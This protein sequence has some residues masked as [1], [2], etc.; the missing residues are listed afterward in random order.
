M[1]NQI[2]VFDTTLRDGTQGEGINLSVQDKLLIA[3]R[4][5][6]FGIDIIE[7]GWPGSNP[8]DEEFF[9]KV[10]RSN[11]HKAEICAFG[12]TARSLNKIEEDQN[13]QAILQ[14]ET[15]VVTIFGKTWKLHSEKGLGISTEENAELIFKSVEFLKKHGKRVIYD[16]E[17]FFDGY[18]DDNE[19]SLKMIK[20]AEAAGA[21][22]IV[23]CDTNGGTLP[24]EVYDIVL[25]LK[26]HIHSP[27]GIHTH[28]DSELAVANSIAAIEAGAV[29]VQGTINGVGERCGN[30][31]LCSI[32]PNLILKLKKTTKQNINLEHLT[33]LS[34][35]VFELMNLTPNSRIAYVGKSAFAHKGGIHV[36]A[37]LKDSRMYEHIDPKV[38]G[39]SQRV[40]VSDLSG[41][42]NI[43]YKAKELGIDL[44]DKKELSKRLVNYIKDLEY[45]GFQFD[46]AEASFELLLRS[47]LNEFLPFFD[48]LDSKVN[49]FYDK[50][51]V[52]KA[53]AVLKIKV[54]GEIEHT[55]AD[56]DGPVNALDN[57]LRKALLRFY[58]D[59]ALIKLVDYKVRVLNEKEGTAAKVRVIIESSDGNETWST[60][61]VSE[62]II[63][64]SFQALRDSINYK[65][66]KFQS[67][68]AKL[69]A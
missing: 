49:V 37:V 2:E 33:S 38:V 60:V 67:S 5:D 17:H 16:A 52:S 63:E 30:A 59:I 22:V 25:K 10:K 27:I 12:S 36:S 14:T 7:G 35:F 41:Q 18:K 45:N 53:E 29:H 47:E 19:F 42:S 6:D 21:D 46:G 58:P 28:N 4:L 54:D 62:D 65:L 26:N 51:G 66:F 61:G 9:E 64:A 57:A 31:N 56:G 43:Y 69:T 23:L 8:R 15:S 44:S 48:V 24:H 11:F 39:N 3:H 20:S 32:I 34:N 13:L 68:K 1:N 50:L 55:A 40:L